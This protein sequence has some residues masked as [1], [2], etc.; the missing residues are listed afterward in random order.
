MPQPQ[1]C[2]AGRSV[3]AV[4]FIH[5]QPQLHTHNHYFLCMCAKYILL[6]NYLFRNVS[7]SLSTKFVI[8]P[9]VQENRTCRTY[10]HI[11]AHLNWVMS[12]EVSG[13]CSFPHSCNVWR[14]CAQKH[15]LINLN[16]SMHMHLSHFVYMTTFSLKAAHSDTWGPWSFWKVETTEQQT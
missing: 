3:P 15:S 13:V 4:H 1:K 7:D 2:I 9:I 12:G 8:S 10:L 6:S 16:V 11:L 5:W 14:N